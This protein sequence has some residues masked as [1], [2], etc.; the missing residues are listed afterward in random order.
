MSSFKQRV[1]FS[2]AFAAFAC[3]Y[4]GLVAGH[5]MMLD[6][7][8]RSSRWRYNSTAPTNYDDNG[9]NCGGMTVQWQKNNGKCG[10]CGDNYAMPMPRQNEIGGYYGGLGVITKEYNNSYTA[11][12]GVRITTNHLGYFRFDLC[13]LSEFGGESEICFAKY[14]LRFVDGSNRLY[15]GSTAGWIVADLVLPEQLNCKHCVLRWTYTGGNNWGPCGNGT[16]ALGCGPQENFVNCADISIAYP[17]NGRSKFYRSNMHSRSEQVN[18]GI[19]E[20]YRQLW[21]YKIKNR[22]M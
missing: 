8:G 3:I 22:D 15:I 7:P 2:L 4:S 9:L 6:P 14:P 21:L 11:R 10:L 12:V 17:I 1:L 20:F 13:N 18:D 16:S 19:P 5:G